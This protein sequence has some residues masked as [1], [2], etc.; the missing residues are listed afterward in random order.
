MGPDE[1]CTW[2]ECSKSATHP[3]IGDAGQW[4][5]L[6]PTHNRELEEA[7]E[8]GSPPVIMRAYVKA[9]GGAKACAEAMME[10]N[11]G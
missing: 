5:N 2:K 9:K 11:N 4:A 1:I 10:K 3:Q 8:R 7:F 6:C